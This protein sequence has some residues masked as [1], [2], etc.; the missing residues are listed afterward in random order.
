MKNVMMMVVAAVCAVVCGC[1]TA[2]VRNEARFKS[3]DKDGVVTERV[4]VNT[5][6]AIGDRAVEQNLKGSL[7]DATEGDLS[8]G[9]QESKQKSESGA[10]IEFLGTLTKEAGGLLGA[11]LSG[12][13]SASVSAPAAV[14]T[15]AE[16]AAVSPPVRAALPEGDAVWVMGSAN[17]ARCATLRRALAGVTEVD[18][19]PLRFEVQGQSQ[20]FEALKSRA[21]VCTAGETV[22]LPFVILSKGGN[23][24]CVGTLAELT[25][26][27]LRDALKL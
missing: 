17:C 11:Y 14:S 22:S 18:G 27:G 7:A 23:V 6:K 9:I 15:A 21:F 25:L 8:A 1:S 10:I 24:V 16:S 2:L 20:Y 26:E 5:I 12:R 13:S 3:V 4:A 19:M